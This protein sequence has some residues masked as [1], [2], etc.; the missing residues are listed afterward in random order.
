MNAAHDIPHDALNL[1][2]NNIGFLPH[3]GLHHRNGLFYQESSRSHFWLSGSMLVA[4]LVISLLPWE[5]RAIVGKLKYWVAGGCV[6]GGI[7][8]VVP[9]FIRNAYGQ[10]ITINPK[11]KTLA[12]RSA[13][14]VGT[15][16]WDQILGLQVC[17]QKVQGNSELN[18][19]QLNLVW[20]ED[21]GTVR[22]YCLLKHTSRAF[23]VRLGRRYESLFAFR[24][25]DPSPESQPDRATNGSQPDRKSTIAGN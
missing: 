25:L 3:V 24:F 11:E 12:I 15:V 6:W 21:G 17:Q 4:A 10:V 23:V 20:V 9:Y 5:T 18:G 1:H 16:P 7:C 14:Y 8:G 22:R 13:D 2:Y 19:C